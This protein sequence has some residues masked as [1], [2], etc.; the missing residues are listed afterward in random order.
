[1]TG[2]RRWRIGELAA[3]TGLTVR[4]LHHYDDLGLL[5]PSERSAAGHRRYTEADVHRLYR[6]LALRQLGLPL[7]DVRAALDTDCDLPALVGEQ[8]RRL[9]DHLL[10]QQRLRQRLVSVLAQLD[11]T[12]RPAVTVLLEAMEGM[13]RMEKYYTDEQ[14]A[15]LAQR[16]QELGAEGMR[17]A[18]QDWVDLIAA[19]EQERAAGTDPADPRVQELAGRWQGLIEQFTGG[20]PGV[21]ASLGRMYAEEG[22][23]SA[24]RGAVDS[25]L[26]EYV[27][28]ALAARA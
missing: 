9:D 7:A 6:V 27:G 21:R 2:V 15:Q 24:S 5:V 11:R 18:E 1:M 16:R 25:E 23:E 13:T 10:A 20:D 28:R 3:A 17:R 22:V 14:Q 12:S 26:M 19:M 4:A 8:L